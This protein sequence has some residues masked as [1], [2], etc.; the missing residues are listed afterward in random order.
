VTGPL[1]RPLE[2]PDHIDWDTL[3]PTTQR[4]LQSR[5][6]QLGR[7]GLNDDEVM[8]VARLMAPARRAS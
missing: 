5:L 1:P 3:S 2:C 6:D 8:F 7:I 4:V